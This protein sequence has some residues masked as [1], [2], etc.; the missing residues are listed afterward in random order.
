MKPVRLLQPVFACF[1]ACVAL[2]QQGSGPVPVAAPPDEEDIPEAPEEWDF[3]KGRGLDPVMLER[4][5]LLVPEGRA[6][7]GLR[8]PVYR[9]S[10]EAPGPALESL[11]ESR[12]VLR[13]DETHLQF[14]GAV[15]STF[16]DAKKPDTATRTVSF[17]NA[18]YDLQLELLYTSSPVKIDDRQMSIHSGG[19]IHDRATGL[20]IF[21]GGVELYLHEPP[22]KPE[23]A[24]PAPSPEP[25]NNPQ[26]SPPAANP[27]SP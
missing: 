20:T 2:A 9:D 10:R 21:T 4:L 12:R 14:E 27:Q 1:A 26:P 11:F 16:D 23:P 13:A 25:D 15:F 7:E 19:M 3:S 6:H 8:Y 22:A 17:I 18:I 5:D 24:A